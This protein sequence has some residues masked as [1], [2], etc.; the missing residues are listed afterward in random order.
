MF[1]QS[2]QITY[3]NK[4]QQIFTFRQLHCHKERCMIWN[5]PIC[6]KNAQN[7]LEPLYFIMQPNVFPT[8]PALCPPSGGT[9]AISLQESETSLPSSPA[10]IMLFLHAVSPA[11]SDR[12]SEWKRLSG[13]LPH[14]GSK[15]R[16]ALRMVEMTNVSKP[17]YT[18]FHRTCA[19][20]GPGS[21]KMILFTAAIWATGAAGGTGTIHEF[22]KHIKELF[23]CLAARFL[24]P[25]VHQDRAG[26]HYRHL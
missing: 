18:Y 3:A 13:T 14:M 4:Q 6:A 11:S 10:V 2:T 7:N 24:L 23:A 1:P 9:A 15:P 19:T 21:C 22:F 16:E 25:L 17:L 26:S 5:L 8:A 12:L 20:G